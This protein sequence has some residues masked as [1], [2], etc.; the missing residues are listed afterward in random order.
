MLITIMNLQ[1]NLWYKVLLMPVMIIIIMLI[2]YN[3]NLSYSQSN[4]DSLIFED[5]LSG[6]QF[7]YTAEDLQKLGNPH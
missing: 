6:V 2:T 4:G 1:Y 5:P 7:Q 3:T